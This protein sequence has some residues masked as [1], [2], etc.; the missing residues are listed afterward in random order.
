MLSTKGLPPGHY[1]VLQIYLQGKREDL[2][3]DLVADNSVAVY[4]HG[5]IAQ[6]V[7]NPQPQLLFEVDWS[8]DPFFS[9]TLKG[10][11][12]VLAVPITGDKLPISWIMLI[13]Q[14]PDG[15][16]IEDL[17]E[18]VMRTVLI[19]SLMES[20]TLAEQLADANEQIEREIREVGQLQRALLPDPFPNVPGLNFAVSYEPSGRAGGDLYD[21]FP[22]D[23]SQQ[24]TGRWCI[25]IGDASG[26]GVAAAVVMAIIHTVLHAH[27]AAVTGPAELLRHANR[28][29]CD[30]KLRGFVT[31]FLAVYE[32]TNRRLTYSSAGHPPPLHKTVNEEVPTELDQANSYPIGIDAEE[33]FQEASIQIS[34]GDLLLLY[35]DG[36]TEA[37]SR[38]GQMLDVPA[39]RQA[40]E[41][42][43]NSPAAVIQRL[44]ALV[45]DHQQGG[46]ALDDQTMVVAKVC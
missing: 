45:R 4:H 24:Q 44:R 8:S 34:P 9:D 23:D 13:R 22:L 3:S 25:L 37:R 29:L 11:D 17:E 18:T 1:R 30:K 38:A 15:L 33:S 16:T 40:F 5:L 19:G 6:I 36:I 2:T 20:Q 32:P 42:A 46:A 39:L 14:S 21:V 31:L 7:S 10:Y 28:H 27:P 35:T 41:I 43:E 26:H 12:S